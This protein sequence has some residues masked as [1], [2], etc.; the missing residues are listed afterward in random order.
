[1]EAEDASGAWESLAT[2]V[3]VEELCCIEAVAIAIGLLN[4]W[5]RLVG[6]LRIY[7]RG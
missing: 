5:S 6:Y 2:R 7:T 4:G 1:M 3:D